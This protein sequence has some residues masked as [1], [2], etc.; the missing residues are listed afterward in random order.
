MAASAQD[1]KQETEFERYQREHPEN[2]CPKCG[3]S[4]ALCEYRERAAREW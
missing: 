3:G 1:K 4:K 2:V